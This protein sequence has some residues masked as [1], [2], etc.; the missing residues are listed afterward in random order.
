MEKILTPSLEDYLK[1]IWEISLKKKTVRVKDIIKKLG[2]KVSSV[3]NALRT[4]KSH[5][6]IIH[7]KYGY[8]ELTYE[9]VKAA[10]DIFERHKKIT[11]FFTQVLNVKKDI[12]IQDACN[13]EH[14]LHKETYENLI[15]FMNYIN[16][17]EKFSS[18]WLNDFKKYSKRDLIRSR[19]KKMKL[20]KLKTGEKGIIKKVTGDISL[21]QR[22]LSMGILP[23][24]R[25]SVEK[26]APLGDPI[27]I[28]IKS[29][30]LTLRKTEA[31]L[32]IVEKL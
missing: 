25:I 19:S 23:N 21:K 18:N 4:L 28:S 3:V 22:L 12:A 1:A 10:K 32:I 16:N 30:H 13:I 15:K 17:T 27:D 2:F 9:G 31:D 20:S 11:F 8:I 14:Y 24:E 26:V 7:E 5:G 6:L 29:Y